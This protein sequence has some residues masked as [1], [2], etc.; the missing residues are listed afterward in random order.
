MSDMTK[1][2]N[3]MV[4]MAKDGLYEADA[5]ILLGMTLAAEHIQNL[6]ISLS[7]LSDNMAFVL[8][9]MD[10]GTWGEKFTKEL[11]EDRKVL[12]S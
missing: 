3:K 10:T 5:S 6:E 9:H 12:K 2:L 7:R 11:E 4:A 8:N 1:E